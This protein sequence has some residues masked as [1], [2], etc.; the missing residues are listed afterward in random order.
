M[1][2][3]MMMVE[4]EELAERGAKQDGGEG[5]GSGSIVWGYL[6]W[7]WCIRRRIAGFG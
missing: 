3:V 6:G 1:V 2:V 4:K 5:C 7:W